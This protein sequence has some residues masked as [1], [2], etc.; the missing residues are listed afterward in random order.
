MNTSLQGKAALIT[1]GS[2][3]IGK[4]IAMAMAAEGAMVAI[5][6]RDDRQLQLAAEEIQVQTKA[7]VV[8]VK[9]NII[10]LNDIHRFVE[11]AVKRFNRVDILVNNAGGANIGGI[12]KTSDE[13]WEY[14]IQ[15]KLLGYIR[16]AREVIP[17]MQT[18]GG[19]NI[20][21]IVGMTAKEPSSLYM[22]PG[23]TDA[24]ILNFTKSLSKELENDNIRV[25]SVNPTTTDTTLTEETF[26]KLAE[27]LQR[28]LEELKHTLISSLPQGRIASVED[29]ANVVLFLASDAAYYINGTSINVDGGRS[30]G[31]W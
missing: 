12:I 30:L 24:A 21:N 3:G 1:G 9:A 8:A 18:A 13:E 11:A 2:K 19:G 7:E 4:A 22:V 20:I 6:A 31:V 15:L 26:Q 27:A 17:H 25:N 23:V 10:K 29:I 16:M 14:H 5:C 28:S